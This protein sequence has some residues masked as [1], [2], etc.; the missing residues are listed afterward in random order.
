GGERATDKMCDRWVQMLPRGDHELGILKQALQ[1]KHAAEE[2]VG[3][4]MMIRSEPASVPLCN[5]AAV[6]YAGMG[7]FARAAR[8]LQEVARLQPDSSAAHYNLG[9]VL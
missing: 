3:Y 5:D 1:S 4:E 8:H 9:T 2:A 6:I 7:E